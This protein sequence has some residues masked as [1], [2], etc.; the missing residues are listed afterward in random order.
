MSQKASSGSNIETSPAVMTSVQRP[1]DNRPKRRAFVLAEGMG[2]TTN[3]S[4]TVG[5]D[6]LVA[7]ADVHRAIQDSSPTGAAPGSGGQ[8]IVDKTYNG[9]GDLANQSLQYPGGPVLSSVKLRL[10]FW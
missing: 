6:D 9:T 1:K 8:Y 2:V 4:E 7:A 10:V 5:A 3:G